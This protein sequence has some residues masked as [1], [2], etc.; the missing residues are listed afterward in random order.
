MMGLQKAIKVILL[1]KHDSVLDTLVDYAEVVFDDGHVERCD[2][3]S[4]TWD[5]DR[6]FP[7]VEVVDDRE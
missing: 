7:D 3:V 1:T 5:C 2:Y 6:W 4:T